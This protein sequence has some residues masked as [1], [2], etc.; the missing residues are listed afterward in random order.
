MPDLT[1]MIEDYWRTWAE[2]E[3]D[4]L[5]ARLSTAEAQRNEAEKRVGHW[6]GKAKRA[7]AVI[8]AA[9]GV[10][11]RPWAPDELPLR[12]G[13][14]SEYAPCKTCGNEYLSF[15]LYGGVC[16]YCTGSL[17]ITVTHDPDCKIC[18]EARDERG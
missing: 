12:G 2:G 1:E 16:Y 14:V 9:K 6:M 4:K 8:E 10:A 11:G 5:Q 15:S 7:E 18:K 3:R 17:V 13:K